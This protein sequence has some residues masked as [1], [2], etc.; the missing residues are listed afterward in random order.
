VLIATHDQRI[1]ERLPATR[2]YRLAEGRLTSGPA[3]EPLIPEAKSA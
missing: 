1:L 3:R 2:I